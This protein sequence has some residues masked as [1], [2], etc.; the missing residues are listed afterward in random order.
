MLNKKY[1]VLGFIASTIFVLSGCASGNK[2]GQYGQDVNT[3]NGN[4]GVNDNNHAGTLKTINGNINIGHH[5]KVKLVQAV[6]GNIYIDDFSQGTSLQTTNGNIVT[7]ENVLVS[8]NV[9]TMNG[10]IRIESRAEIGG[11]VIADNGDIF[12]AQGTTVI[13]DIIFEKRGFWSSHFDKYIPT[14][15]IAEEVTIKGTIHLYRPIKLL[16]DHSINPEEIIHH[17]DDRK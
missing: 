1:L 15:E 8:G 13:G 17:Y 3:S 12:I 7:G 10:N 16:L 5:A 9:K 6:N 11:S 14:L 2:I 4:I